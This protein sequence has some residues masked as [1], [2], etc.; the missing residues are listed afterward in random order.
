MRRLVGA[1][2]W[3]GVRRASRRC[4]C[5]LSC[6][7]RKAPE[8]SRVELRGAY[9]ETTNAGPFMGWPSQ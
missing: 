7:A 5:S 2:H 4:L 6:T 8:W 9:L 3:L 1:R